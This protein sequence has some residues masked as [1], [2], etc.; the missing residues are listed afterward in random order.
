MRIG[1]VIFIA[2][3]NPGHI[4]WTWIVFCYNV[5]STIFVAFRHFKLLL[6]HISCRCSNENDD[7]HFIFAVT[8]TD[9]MFLL[10]M[11]LFDVD[12]FQAQK[13]LSWP[14]GT[15]HN[16]INIFFSNRYD[17]GNRRR[18]SICRQWEDK[19][20]L[21]HHHFLQS[22]RQLSTSTICQTILIIIVKIPLFKMELIH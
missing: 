12:S 18:I 4:S 3:K 7:S 6:Q 22:K 5:C 14:N 21:K 15:S 13:G 1:F 17:K 11:G 16:H 8:W 9:P 10:V 20:H 19:Y 2:M